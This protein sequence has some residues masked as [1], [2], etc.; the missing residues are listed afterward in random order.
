M[1]F[2][3]IGKCR[4]HFKQYHCPIV[5][6]IVKFAAS[7]AVTGWIAATFTQTE[8]QV[9]HQKKNSNYRNKTM[10]FATTNVKK[11][12]C[13]KRFFSRFVSA[14]PIFFSLCNRNHLKVCN[15]IDRKWRFSNTYAKQNKTKSSKK[16]SKN[17]TDGVYIFFYRFYQST[18][19]IHRKYFF[20]HVC[21]V[22]NLNT[23]NVPT[24]KQRKKAPT[25]LSYTWKE[26]T[27]KNFAHKC[28]AKCRTNP[29]KS[30][31]FCIIC[32]KTFL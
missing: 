19:N 13:I 29:S 26:I 14:F 16:M 10:E 27:R 30:R 25:F 31:L 21:N 11:N 20:R 4:K 7:K 6:V 3:V 5:N 24:K 12:I 23:D 18:T 8:K 22:C 1:L 28:S 9:K 2:R 32:E 15:I 17:L